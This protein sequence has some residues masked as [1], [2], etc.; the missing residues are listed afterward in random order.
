YEP[1]RDRWQRM[2]PL[3][4]ARSGFSAVTIPGRRI[5]AFGGEELV[6]DGRTVAQVELFGAATRRWSEL[7]PMRT[8]RH[9]LGGVSDG[10]RVLALEGGPRPGLHFSDAAERLTVPR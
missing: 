8:P 2:P 10:D 6:P 3:T 9:G 1:R 5:V 4:V 7:A